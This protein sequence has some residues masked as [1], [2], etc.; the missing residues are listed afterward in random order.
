MKEFFSKS[1]ELAA[2]AKHLDTGRRSIR[3]GG[4]GACLKAMV[5]SYLA[6]ETGK[7]LVIITSDEEA[8]GLFSAIDS[9][10]YAFSAGARTLYYPED[11][12]IL[13]SGI[14]ASKE[15]S[16]ARAVVYESLAGEG[17]K[18][19]VTDVNAVAEKIRNPDEVKKFKIRLEQGK[20]LDL[21]RLLDALAE[22]NYRRCLK[23]EDVYEY[24]VRGSIIDVFTPGR[25]YPLRIELFGN[26]VESLRLFSLDTY[27]ATDNIKTAEIFLFNPGNR[28]AEGAFS[29]L[30]YLPSEKTALIIDGVE[31]LRS[32]IREKA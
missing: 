9:L 25:A 32:G 11:D 16:K 24:S 26:T 21:E 18:I 15:V 3:A 13:Y 20:T 30:D 1:K 5:Y 8:Y 27:S 19:I 2:I 17:R 7:N 23:V 29:V 12:S 31:K 10:K 22:N 6:S 28:R 4:I 14:E